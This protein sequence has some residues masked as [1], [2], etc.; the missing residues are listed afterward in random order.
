[1]QRG[2]IKL[3]IQSKPTVA[4][5]TSALAV[6]CLTATSITT[7]LRRKRSIMKRCVLL[8]V[9][10]DVVRN[11]RL[12][13]S[14]VTHVAVQFV[15]IVRT[16]QDRER[17]LSVQHHVEFQMSE[18]F[19][20]ASFTWLESPVQVSAMSQSLTASRHVT[21]LSSY[22]PETTTEEDRR[23]R[24]GRK[25]CGG[26]NQGLDKQ[27]QTIQLKWYNAL[28][29]LTLQSLQQ[30]PLLHMALCVRVHFLQQ[31]A[32]LRA[33]SYESNRGL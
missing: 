32:P 24:E 14:G 5:Q 10:G 30:R 27:Q 4:P 8:N 33:H 22:C 6:S 23:Q 12:Y 25:T 9:T 31:F 18:L 13:L 29:Q 3:N 7:T 19:L 28:K 17:Y 16:L 11:I 15:D 1:M 20:E 2:E 26:V 21:P